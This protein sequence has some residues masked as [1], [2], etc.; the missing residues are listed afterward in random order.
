MPAQLK[1]NAADAP[2]G[3]IATQGSHS[4]RQFGVRSSLKKLSPSEI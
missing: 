4:Y 1:L 3:A 2:S